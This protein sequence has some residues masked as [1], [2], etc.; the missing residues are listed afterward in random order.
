M[1]HASTKNLFRKSEAE[2]ATT[3]G[4]K[5]CLRTLREEK[6]IHEESARVIWGAV[7]KQ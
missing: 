7:R 4:E 1:K 2:P 6:T 3:K 5:R